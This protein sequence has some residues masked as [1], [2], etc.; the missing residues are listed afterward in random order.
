MSRN[1]C[2][3]R[4]NGNDFHSGHRKQNSDLLICFII[5]HVSSFNKKE[6]PNF[7]DYSLFITSMIIISQLPFQKSLNTVVIPYI[8]VNFCKSFSCHNN[9]I[10]SYLKKKDMCG[11]SFV[12]PWLV[13]YYFFVII[14]IEHIIFLQSRHF[15]LRFSAVSVNKSSITVFSIHYFSSTIWILSA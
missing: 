4:R 1:A 10:I 12:S 2:E 8:F 11:Q 5:S 14:Q 13:F 9:I 6:Q 7:L 15:K 3:N